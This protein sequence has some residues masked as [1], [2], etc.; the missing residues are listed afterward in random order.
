MGR[1]TCY[2][3]LGSKQAGREK[4]TA[5]DTFQ[6]SPEHQPGADA[7]SKVLKEEGTTL[8]RFRANLQHIGLTDDVNVLC[9]TS[10]EAVKN[11]DRPIRFLFIDADH[12]YEACLKD[13]SLWAPHVAEC[14]LIAFHDYGQAEGVTRLCDE[15]RQH[16]DDL[17]EFGL[18]A[19]L[20]VFQKRSK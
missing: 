11:W 7:E 4:V 19:S 18:S 12:S 10:E 6:G 17:K 3:A 9:A 15:L 14:G 20:F 1:S 2:L 16:A 13:Y 8:N 5:I